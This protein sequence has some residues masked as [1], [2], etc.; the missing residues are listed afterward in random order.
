MILDEVHIGGVINP[1]VNIQVIL[2]KD[3]ELLVY[4]DKK[5]VQFDET[6]VLGRDYVVNIVNKHFDQIKKSFSKKIPFASKTIKLEVVNKKDNNII[7]NKKYRVDFFYR[8]FLRIRFVLKKMLKI[9]QKIIKIL[10]KY[11]FI[12]PPK[13]YKRFVLSFKNNI[14][15]QYVNDNYYNPLI[16]KDYLKWL[17]EN[18]QNR[19][20]IDELKYNPKISILIP[21]NSGN[22]K[23]INECIDSIL[24]QSYKNY[25]LIILDNYSMSDDVLNKLNVA[26]IKSKKYIPEIIND[27]ISKITGDFTLIMNPL[28]TLCKNALYNVVSELSKKAN[29][30][31][32]YSDDD[33]ID[34]NGK[35]CFPNF[36]P[37]YSPDSLLSLNYIGNLVLFRTSIIKELGGFEIK[38]KDNYFYNFILR[39]VEV[40]NNIVH[41]PK[42]LYHSRI[43]T[44]SYYLNLKEN[45][46]LYLSGK[47][48]LEDKFKRL[49]INANVSCLNNLQ[50]YD[51]DYL[52]DKEPQI[53]IIIPTKDKAEIL[54][55]CLKS[56]YSKTNYKNYNIIVIN[57]NS[58]KKETYECLNSYKNNNKNFDYINMN[59]EFNYSNINNEAVK[60]AK[61]EYIV[62]LN[63]DIEIISSNW[64]SKMVGFAM[65]KHIGCVGI[66][67]L[68]PDNTVQHC[69]VIIG[70]GGVAGHAFIR[71]GDDNDGY[72]GRL[73]TSYDCSA[74]TAACLMINKEK[75]NEVNG[76]DEKLKVAYNDVDL[77]LKILEK[78]YNNVCIS[79]I[80]AYHY[81]SLSRGNDFNSNNIKRFNDEI[82]YMIKK[83][84]EKLLNDR[85]YN[86]NLS[87]YNSYY[88]DRKGDN[89]EKK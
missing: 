67:L 74:V 76:F 21:V 78:G 35:F 56:I 73:S 69:G 83:W 5:K 44:D 62:F 89:Y 13:F 52:Y 42:I 27:N 14:N 30:D 50:L 48:V 23:Y 8:L 38:Y 26:F 84:G 2:N 19:E 71:V 7:Y 16:K 45:K 87:Y 43:T 79:S 47:N 11:K 32:I 20:N 58:C 81:E 65:Q 22:S 10:V 63:N 4:L 49:K 18:E 51:I 61:G 15:Y 66:K 75:F 88:L 86:V 6:T 28:D 46:Y 3:C 59:C 85:F 31:M 29:V 57:N 24:N 37:D 60:R 25:E 54:D 12:I 70:L 53:T 39:F 36:K 34:I 9:L 55:K 1:V 77:N 82:N 17:E 33:K 80:K 68:Y 72:Y 40:T 64:L 41:I